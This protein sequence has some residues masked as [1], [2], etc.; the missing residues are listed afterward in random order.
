VQNV[1]LVS[2][3][4]ARARIICCVHQLLGRVVSL[5]SPKL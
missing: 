3:H 2:F 4:G 1:L 5:E